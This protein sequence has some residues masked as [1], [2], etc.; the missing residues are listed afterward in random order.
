MEW[1]DEEDPRGKT[2]LCP[3]CGI[4]SV[5]GSK[6][7]YPITDEYFIEEIHRFWFN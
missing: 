1:C 2:A 7:G 3:N 6:S 5:I 4:D